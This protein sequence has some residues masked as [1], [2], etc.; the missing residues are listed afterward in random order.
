MLTVAEIERVAGFLTEPGTRRGGLLG[1]DPE[2]RGARGPAARQP[3]QGA[4]GDLGAGHGVRQAR[5]G[6]LPAPGVAGVAGRLLP[7]GR[8]GRARPRR[9]DRRAGAQRARTSGSGTTSPPPA[10]RTSEQ[11]EQILDVLA[12]EPQSLPALETATGIRRGRL[13]TVLKILAVDDAV[14][15]QGSGWV[16]TGKALVLRRGEVGRAAEGPGRRGRPDAPVRARRGLP[17]AVPAAGPG[18]PGSAARAGAARSATGS[19]RPRDFGRRRR[20]S[21]RGPALLPRP[22]RGRR[23][24]QDVG[25]RT[26]RQARARS[27]SSAT[28][29]AMAYADDPAWSGVLADLWRQDGEAPPEV[30]DGRGRGA[31]ALVEDLAAADRGGGDAVAALPGAGRARWP[32]TSPGSAGCRWSRRSPCPVRRRREDAASSVRARDLLARTSLIPGVGLRRAGAAG[33]RQ[34]PHPLDRH[35]GRVPAGRGRCLDGAPARAPPAALTERAEDRISE[36]SPSGPRSGT[37]RR[38]RRSGPRGRG[39]HGRSTW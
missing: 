39:E 38:R 6:V 14:T 11:V 1:A 8:S 20:R 35:R 7:A 29:R 17:D 31:E 22:G 33:R 4:G 13:E 36:G 19:C 15:R 18:R 27:V 37:S 21:S 32:P 24:A 3:G 10:S 12:E 9:R 5:P 26:A 25:Q 16:A 23:A 34:D 30:L 28:G 2:P